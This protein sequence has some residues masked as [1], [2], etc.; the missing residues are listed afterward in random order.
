MFIAVASAR[1][2]GGLSAAWLCS[3]TQSPW[4]YAFADWA[5]KRQLGDFWQQLETWELMP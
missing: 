1:T 3:L 2:S 5:K 4:Q